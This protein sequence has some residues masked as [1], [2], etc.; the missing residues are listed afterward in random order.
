M[1]K[2]PQFLIVVV[3]LT[4]VMLACTCNFTERFSLPVAEIGPTATSEATATA[5]Q[6]ATYTPDVEPTETQLPEPTDAEPTPTE[7]LPTEPPTPTPEPT[8]GIGSTMINPIDGAPLVYVPEGAFQKG[9]EDFEDWSYAEELPQQVYLEAYWIYQHPVTNAQFAAFV[10]DSGYQTTAEA[11]G[12][13]VVWD[14]STYVDKEGYSWAAPYGPGS[15]VE[16]R[17][18]HPVVFVNGT[19]A[20][21]YCQW[22]GGRLPTE[23]EWEKAARGTDDRTFP[24]GEESPTCSLANFR[25]CVDDTSPVGSYPLGASPYGALD[26]AGNVSEWVVE[27]ITESHH[28]W[29]GGSWDSGQDDLR[30]FQRSWIDPVEMH[31]GRGFRCL[32]LP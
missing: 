8:L 25:G 29:R 3:T 24:W 27:W 18:D 10:E 17:E 30:V 9:S 28:V 22:A 31:T 1:K 15:S 6:A 13:N 26:M 16:G 20:E 5:T 12:W 7:P 32:H 11:A 23:A 14:G 21:A 4:L 2:R 19:D